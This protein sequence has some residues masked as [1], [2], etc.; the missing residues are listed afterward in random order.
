MLLKDSAMSGVANTLVIK[1]KYHL[2]LMATMNRSFN[3]E[4]WYLYFGCFW[5]NWSVAEWNI[6]EKMYRK[7]K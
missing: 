4:F 5:E 1:L 7:I 3:T 2:A 6:L